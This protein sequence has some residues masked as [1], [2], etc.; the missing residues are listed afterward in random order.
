MVILIYSFIMADRALHINVS[1]YVWFLISII[2]YKLSSP[3][4]VELLFT[5]LSSSFHYLW[6]WTEHHCLL[7]LRFL[8]TSLKGIIF[9]TF[10]FFIYF[11]VS[12]KYKKV[13]GEGIRHQAK[14]QR[15][16]IRERCC[17]ISAPCDRSTEHNMCTSSRTN[18]NSTG[19]KKRQS[20]HGSVLCH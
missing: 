4:F 9:P 14:T 17:H 2:L 1:L 15:T 5:S 19:K 18:R 6:K 10:L 16:D 3:G 12:Q 20:C 8:S 7:W 11:I 13:C